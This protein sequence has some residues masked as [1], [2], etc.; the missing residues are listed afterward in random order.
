MDWLEET[1]DK[2]QLHVDSPK[3]IEEIG[4]ALLLMMRRLRLLPPSADDLDDPWI[5]LVPL[6]LLMCLL[7]MLVAW[8]ILVKLMNDWWAVL[9]LL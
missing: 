9:L 4:V 2:M 5:Q 6:W 1:K 7:Q 8:V 3:A